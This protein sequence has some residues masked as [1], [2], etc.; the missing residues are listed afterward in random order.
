M[1]SPILAILK[2]DMKSL[3]KS[4]MLA[5]LTGL[6][7]CL[8]GVFF[9]FTL[10]QFVTQS[11]Q[12]S[13]TNMDAGL[14]IHHN[15]IASYIVVVHYILVFVVAA[16]SL[17]F[18]T[19]EKKLK[20]F[21]ILLTSPMTSWQIVVAKWLVGASL[22]LGLLAISAVFPLSL[23]FFIKIPLSLFFL[24]YF[25]VFIIL[26]V[27]MSAGLL[28]SAMTE[29][30]IVCVVLSLVFNILLLLMG[31]GRELTDI[32]VL[33]EI[34]N[35]LSIDHHF[36]YFRKGLVNLSSIFYFLSWSFFLGLVTER[37][38]EFNRWR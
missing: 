35:F 31:V 14:N 33:Q 10:Y 1:I 3:V 6:C 2:K 34:F 30:L 24:S 37:I 32:T 8:W 22:I 16:F 13:A 18:F 15:L 12:M 5:L 38:I 28:A 17:R 26:C 4:P 20:T 29:S 23:M 36:A 11:F 25:G 21:P 7:C 9:T 19:E 27:Y